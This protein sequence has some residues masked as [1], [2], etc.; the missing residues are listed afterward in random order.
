M[1]RKS[2]NNVNKFDLIFSL[3]FYQSLNLL[4]F[5]KP[6]HAFESVW[7]FHV[8]VFSPLCLSIECPISP[9]FQATFHYLSK[10]CSER[11]I[12]FIAAAAHGA[13]D[14][15]SFIRQFEDVPKVNVSCSHNICSSMGE[16]YLYTC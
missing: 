15:E 2:L 9:I 3:I 13:V 16:L 14:E 7:C 11:L 4:K 6:M 5:I 10:F 8:V 12:I 1:S